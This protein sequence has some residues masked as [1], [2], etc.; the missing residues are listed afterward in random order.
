MLNSIIRTVKRQNLDA[1]QMNSQIVLD[2]L[3]RLLNLMVQIFETLRNDDNMYETQTRDFSLGDELKK[4]RNP[5][6]SRR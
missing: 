4:L 5:Q 2:H 6:T 3:R 1:F